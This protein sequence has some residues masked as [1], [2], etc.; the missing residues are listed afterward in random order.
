M[1]LPCD[2]ASRASMQLPCDVPSRASMQ[3]PCDVPSRASMQL[4][5]A[6]YLCGVLFDIHLL[7]IL[8]NSFNITIGRGLVTYKI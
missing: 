7:L 8:I 6:G 1:Q 5:A 3:L 2:V 4:L